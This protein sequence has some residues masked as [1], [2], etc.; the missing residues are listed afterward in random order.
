ML[1]KNIC[2]TDGNVKLV[3]TDPEKELFAVAVLIPVETVRCFVHPFSVTPFLPEKRRTERFLPTAC[4]ALP[5]LSR[6]TA[7]PGSDCQL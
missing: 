5:L 2:E 3:K 4:N 7:S 6:W 1:T